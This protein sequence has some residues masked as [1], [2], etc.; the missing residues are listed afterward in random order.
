MMNVV[1]KTEGT[2]TPST[3]QKEEGEE[4]KQENVGNE[5]GKADERVQLN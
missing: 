2:D 3:V 4:K 1:E 5:E